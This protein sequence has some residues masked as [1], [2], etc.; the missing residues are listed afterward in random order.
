M[1]RMHSVLIGMHNRMLGPYLG[2]PQWVSPTL[3]A[4]YR[5]YLQTKLS[6]PHYRPEVVAQTT[7]INFCVTELGLEQQLLV[8]VRWT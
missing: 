2:D 4:L 5:L 8:Q 6:N 3:A 1:N 7:L